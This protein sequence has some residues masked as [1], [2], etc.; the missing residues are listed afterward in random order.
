MLLTEVVACAG[1]PVAEDVFICI[2]KGSEAFSFK[3][4]AYLLIQ[5][6]AKLEKH[7]ND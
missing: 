2:N 3:Q 4:I 7:I 5:K 6:N 1:D